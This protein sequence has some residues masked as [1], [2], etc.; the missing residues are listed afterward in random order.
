M[1]AGSL[2]HQR[3]QIT[4]YVLQTCHS[5]IKSATRGGWG[6]GRSAVGNL[7]NLVGPRILRL[8]CYKII[9]NKHFKKLQIWAIPSITSVIQNTVI[10]LQVYNSSTRFFILRQRHSTSSS[11]ST[12]ARSRSP[13]TR[14]VY[15]VRTP[16]EL[17]SSSWH[18]TAAT[19]F[20]I[21]WSPS[22]DLFTL[23]LTVL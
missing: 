18:T 2:S 21:L 14:R 20:K 1:H 3:V 23:I 7:K 10:L 15:R 13:E 6:G 11:P 12:E 16:P 5:A 17:H 19:A 8:S 9:R 22:S 4:I